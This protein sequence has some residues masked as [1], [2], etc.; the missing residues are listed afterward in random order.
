MK[1]LNCP[2]KFCRPEKKFSPAG[3]C[4]LFASILAAAL[5]AV[6]FTC[7]FFPFFTA[8]CYA[9]PINAGLSLKNISVSGNGGSYLI[10]FK[11]NGK[12]GNAVKKVGLNDYGL[13]IVF[14]HAKSGINSK[15]IKL[16]GR[17]FK[18]VELLPYKNSGLNAIIYFHKNIK[19]S[20]KDTYATFYGDYFIVKVRHAFAD[21]LF[22][23]VGKKFSAAA[24]AGLKR[25][26]A[27]KTAGPG[28]RPAKSVKNAPEPA[29]KGAPFISRKAPK[30]N[31]GFEIIKTAFYLILVIGLIYGIYFFMEKFKNRV[32]PKEKLNNLKIV[33][34]INLGNKKSI[35]LIE[36]NREFF[37][38]GVSPSNIQVIG[39]IENKNNAEGVLLRAAGESG[40]ALD[41]GAFADGVESGSA[42]PF[43][44]NRP[45]AAAKFYG[46]FADVLREQV[47]AGADA[48]TYD[49]AGFNGL[50]EPSQRIKAEQARDA[51]NISGKT[52]IFK[53]KNISEAKLKNKTDNVFFDIEERLKGLMESN[54]VSKKF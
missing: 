46:K 18:A 29:R 12:P 19:I 37:L 21:D 41:A 20:K 8:G 28:P 17:L 35:L 42:V 13:G 51:A 45:S 9:S 3:V 31:L 54:G 1:K 43:N 47:D 15:F 22:K 36:V 52:D 44:H 48:R 27:S 14:R 50:N 32:S 23:N 11:F 24:A 40:A 30:L 7:F 26:I 34:S 38:V 2:D 10:W 16:D 39:R 49:G 4:F 6:L 53:I 33:S 25:R 5:A